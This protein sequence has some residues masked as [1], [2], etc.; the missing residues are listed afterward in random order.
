MD[1]FILVLMI[2]S[3][4]LASVYFLTDVCCLERIGSTIFFAIANVSLVNINIALFS[5]IY[6]NSIVVFITTLATMFLF[7]GLIILKNKQIGNIKNLICFSPLKDEFQ[8]LGILGSV[9]VF[10]FFYYSNSEFL[11]SLASYFVKEA[12]TCF[13]MQTFRIIG[14]FNPGVNSLDALTKVYDII[15]TPGNV[16][17]TATLLPI[18]KISS[19]KILYLIFNAL[20]F[21]FTYLICKRLLKNKAAALTVAIFSILNPYILSVEVL[22]RNVMALSISAFFFYCLLEHKEEIFLQGFVFG[23]LAGTGLRFLP[24][25]SIVPMLI[26]WG[27]DVNFKKITL[28]VTAFLITFLFNIPHIFFNGL[29]SLGESG[30]FFELIILAFTKWMRTPFVPFPNILFYLINLI[31]Y[32][33][34]LVSG[35][36]CFGAYSLLKENKRLFLAF[37]SMFLLV[38]IALSFQRNWI[39]GDKYRIIICAFLPVYIFLGFGIKSIFNR[40]NFKKMILAIFISLS[41]PIIFVNL[42]SKLNFPQDLEFYKRRLIYQQE[43]RDYYQLLKKSLSNVGVFPNYRRLFTKL[44]LGRKVKEER[45]TFSNLFPKADL[46]GSDKFNTFYKQWGKYF[47]KNLNDKNATLTSNPNDFVYLKINFDKLILDMHNA[48]TQLPSVEMVSLDLSNPE[49]L[50]D[51]FYAQIKVSWQNNDLPVC[52]MLNNDNLDVFK[53]LVINLNAFISVGKDDLGL[54]IVNAVNFALNPGLRKYGYNS[55]MTSFPLYE[56]DR[57]LI[58]KVPKDTKIIIKNWFING[59]NGIPFKVDSWGIER[60]FNG[61]YGIK[62]YYNEPE[63]YL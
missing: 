52:L 41:L 42:C 54:D 24:L 5:G 59:Q 4:F 62:F 15:C 44:K 35:F 10:L 39:E 22:D 45:S 33:G 27:K 31:N 20:L 58:F 53:E 1:I 50:S 29:N 25:L 8:A 30:S 34:Y 37:L 21:I 40:I 26:L 48:V 55:G 9:L 11:L 12:A 63:S 2:F 46:P 56:E 36:I 6:L 18:L 16:L 7:L 13:Y 23:L 43:S 17:F 60:S 51:T 61:R 32:F 38:I 47:I 57:S 14:L 49:Q 19:F 3:G 28:F